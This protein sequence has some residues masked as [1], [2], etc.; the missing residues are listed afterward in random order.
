MYIVLVSDNVCVQLAGKLALNGSQSSVG[1]SVLHICK[2][3]Q[4]N[5]NYV[6][7]SPLQFGMLVNEYVSALCSEKD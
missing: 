1:K 2:L 3:L 6:S 7:S 5:S 4:C